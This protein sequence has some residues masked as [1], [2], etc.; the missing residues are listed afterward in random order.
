MGQSSLPVLKMEEPQ[1]SK[2]LQPLTTHC[3]PGS[4]EAGWHLSIMG[5]VGG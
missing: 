2:L 3:H 1:R 4:P 5:N